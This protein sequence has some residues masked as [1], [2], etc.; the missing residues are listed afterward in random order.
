M[1][2]VVQMEES[3]SELA[4]KDTIPDELYFGLSPV[5]F[6]GMLDVEVPACLKNCSEGKSNQLP[7]NSSKMKSP[8]LSASSPKLEENQESPL[9][10][11][12]A[13]EIL[14]GDMEETPAINK[15]R[16]R[17]LNRIMSSGNDETSRRSF[18]ENIPIV[19]VES[20]NKVKNLKRLKKLNEVEDKSAEPARLVN[21]LNPEK[22]RARIHAGKNRQRKPPL[23]RSGRL[24]EPI[25][26][27]L[28]K[29]EDLIRKPKKKKLSM[30]DGNPFF[31]HE[32]EVDMFDAEGRQINFD[33]AA[34]SDFEHDPSLDND[35]VGFIATTQ[36][37][38]QPAM[39]KIYLK[40]IQT[41]KISE[42]AIKEHTRQL[43]YLDDGS[44][45]SGSLADFVMGDD[46][47]PI[48]ATNAHILDP[49][50]SPVVDDSPKSPGMKSSNETPW[51]Q[52]ANS[53]QNSQFRKPV[54]L[55]RNQQFARPRSNASGKSQFGKS[56][57]SQTAQTGGDRY[58]ISSKSPAPQFAVPKSVSSTSYPSNFRGGNSSSTGNSSSSSSNPGQF[59]ARG[60]SQFRKGFRPPPSIMSQFAGRIGRAVEKK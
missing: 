54:E 53:P 26:P 10:S 48:P 51:R 9:H 38:P 20:S 22:L 6:F 59:S 57:E 30:R 55:P 14:T 29:K 1:E 15:S 52:F 23:Q 16:K 42:E 32:A 11:S 3:L 28:Q 37:D 12:A 35:L 13:P 58:G 27:G 36:M 43:K 39:E 44:D 17:H 31:D 8:R 24:P 5:G 40:S 47:T 7:I 33:D 2:A 4:T 49:L 21:A 50:D 60:G 18:P 56:N 34:E 46:Q 41:E 25:V 45:S 19:E